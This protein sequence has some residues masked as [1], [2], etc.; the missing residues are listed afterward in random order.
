MEHHVGIESVRQELISLQ[1]EDPQIVVFKH[2][3][4]HVKGLI[5]VCLIQCEK[6][7]CVPV[8]CVIDTYLILR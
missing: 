5:Q 3:V 7:V 4:W 1:P 8:M 6:K 2:G